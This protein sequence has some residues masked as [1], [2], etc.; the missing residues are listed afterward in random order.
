MLHTGEVE[1]SLLWG[2][3]WNRLDDP[4]LPPP[5]SWTAPGCWSSPRLTPAHSSR[6]AP[7]RPRRPGVDHPR[8]QPPRRRRPAPQLPPGPHQPTQRRT[9]PA[10]RLR[11]PGPQAMA[12]VLRAV[13]AVHRT[14]PAPHS[15]R[16]GPA[17]LTVRPRTAP[18]GSRR[19][20]VV[21]LG[22]PKNTTGLDAHTKVRGR[23]RGLAVD[24]LGLVIGVV[25][26]ASS[27]H[28]TRDHCASSYVST[29]L[30]FPRAGAYGY[31][32]ELGAPCWGLGTTS[33]A[34]C[35]C[36]PLGT[37]YR[38]RLRTRLRDRR[39]ECIAGAHGSGRLPVGRVRRPHLSATSAAVDGHPWPVTAWIAWV[40]RTG[41]R[42]PNLDGKIKD[43]AESQRGIVRPA[44]RT[45]SMAARRGRGA[46]A[47]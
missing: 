30:P 37:N 22:L 20:P 25:V 44:C 38:R 31:R 36:P 34:A 9:P 17:R 35:P 10:A 16:S 46:R 43:S 14:R 13:A 29:T 47:W 45:G 39:V 21:R 8:R 28:D 26:L 11:R 1:Q 12:R 3:E 15:N 4:A 19:P 5:T 42:E 7:R 6:R 24:V 2:Y 32:H 40:R 18:P 41:A 33:K 27:A 23:E